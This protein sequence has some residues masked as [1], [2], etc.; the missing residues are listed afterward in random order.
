MSEIKGTV[1]TKGAVKGT[2]TAAYGKD[3][4]SAYEIA[5]KNGFEGTE[6]EWLNSL[7]GADGT[8]TF[9]DL[10]EEQKASLKGDKG[11]KGD[12]GERFTY[13][14]F[15]AEQL[16]SLKGEKGDTGSS[17]VYVG[18]G[19]MPED[20]NVQIDTNGEVLTLADIVREVIAQS[21][22]ISTVTLLANNWEGETSPYYQT[23]DILG[24]PENSKIDLN[25]TIEQLNIFHEKDITFVVANRNGVITVYCIG[26]KPTN[27]YTIQVSII[28][29]MRYE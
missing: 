19:D 13:A 16:L 3:G 8:M 23:V 11:D 4:K 27:D 24:A 22:K 5:L 21:N 9:E 10:T 12:I 14:D 29:V 17:G 1:A 26:Q 18:S 7:K 20:C 6:Q 15:T 2:V 25:P 28:E